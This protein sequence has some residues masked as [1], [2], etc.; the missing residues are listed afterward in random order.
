MDACIAIGKIKTRTEK[1][2]DKKCK[3]NAMSL[4]DRM[5]KYE[6][7]TTELNLVPNLPIYA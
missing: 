2:P 7:V 4:A 5:K 3:P 1:M 6:E